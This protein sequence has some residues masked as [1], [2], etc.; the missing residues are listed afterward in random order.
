MSNSAIHINYGL[1]STLTDPATGLRGTR[2][3]VNTRVTMPLAT[4][5]YEVEFYFDGAGDTA[6]LDLATGLGSG[7]V[8]GVKAAG[9]VVFA[10]LPVADETFTV[11]ANIYTFK[12]TAANNTQV[13][14]GAD[15][16]ATGANSVT[17][18]EANDPALDSINFA[19]TVTI[20][21]AFTGAYGN[22]IGLAAAATNVTVSGAFLTGGVDAVTITGDGEDYLGGALPVAAKIHALLVICSSGNAVIEMAGVLLNTVR[23]DG[24][25]QDWSRPGRTDLIGS[26]AV[27]SGEAG[28]RVKVVVAASE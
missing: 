6:T 12:A 23:P 16:T 20:S 5:R 7:V 4:I 17:S 1:A 15:A 13:T 11:N 14:I 27:T 8:P 25:H 24:G 18:V 3:I 9:T 22:A 2:G 28:T 26:L 21:A 19:G 10:G